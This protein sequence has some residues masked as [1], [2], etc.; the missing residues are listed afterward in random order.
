MPNF[1]FLAFFDAAWLGARVGC[2]VRTALPGA[3]ILLSMLTRRI[4]IVEANQ[5][6]ADGRPMEPPRQ[7]TQDTTACNGRIIRYL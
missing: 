7:S 3:P 6:P 2:P 4:R 5:G 1:V